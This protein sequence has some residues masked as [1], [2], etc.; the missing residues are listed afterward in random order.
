MKKILLIL[1]LAFVVAA[2]ALA[3]S[4]G[5]KTYSVEE[6]ERILQNTGKSLHAADNGCDYWWLEYGGDRHIIQENE[7]IRSTLTRLVYGV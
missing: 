4:C 3:V 7:S 6:I 2:S 5:A 1:S